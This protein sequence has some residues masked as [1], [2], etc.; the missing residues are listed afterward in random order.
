LY[1]ERKDRLLAKIAVRLKDALADRLA[2]GASGRITARSVASGDGWRVEDVLCTAGPEDQPYEEEHRSVSIAVVMSG[3]FQYRTTGGSELM[4]PGSVLLGN[5]GGVFEC[6]HAHARGDHCLAFH[7]SPDHF[8]RI[9]ADA[10]VGAADRHFRA[11]RLPPMRPLAGIGARACVALQVSTAIVWEEAA[12]DLAATAVQLSHGIPEQT[13]SVPVGAISRVTRIARMVEHAVDAPLTLAELAREA[14]L[15]PYHFLRTFER[16][17]GVTPHQFILR[18]RL[19]TAAVRLA[20]EPRTVL[21][22]ALDCGFG[23][24]S[25]FNRAFRRE[26]GTSPRAYR[27]MEHPP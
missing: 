12:V 7:Y 27:S 10:G 17:T 14:R 3:T 6:G 24:L 25:N 15:S 4:T 11:V 18:T 1:P 9:A 2:N 20:T 22:I 23:D 16:V 26:F 19:R 8:E 13:G 5:A 21:D